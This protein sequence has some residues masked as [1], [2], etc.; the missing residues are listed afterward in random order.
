MSVDLPVLGRPTTAMRIG[1]VVGGGRIGFI[2]LNLLGRVRQ[3][4]AQR[5]VEA[6]SDP[7]HARR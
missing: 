7:R 3:R 1:L 4:L 6:G 2:M 5:I